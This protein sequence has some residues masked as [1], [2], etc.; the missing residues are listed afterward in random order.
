MF[1]F[2]DPHAPP[3]HHLGGSYTPPPGSYTPPPIKPYRPP[4]PTSYP[5]TT[6]GPPLSPYKEAGYSQDNYL[7]SLHH[8][9]HEEN[10]N[11]HQHLNEVIK[12]YYNPP[13]ISP[14]LPTLYYDD[15]GQIK[16]MPKPKLP[17]LV[18]HN[19]HGHD[20]H[21]PPKS[22][23]GL[24][25]YDPRNHKHHYKHAGTNVMH[26]GSD[27]APPP[28]HNPH[29]NGY[30]VSTLAP[31][32]PPFIKNIFHG[33]THKPA[34]GHGS[35]TPY[36]LWNKSTTPKPSYYGSTTPYSKVKYST[37]KPTT[38]KS[39]VINKST[40]APKIH[41]NPYAYSPT[42]SPST[43]LSS[44][45]V[46]SAYG[47][48]T[49]HG[50]KEHFTAL[51]T[52][53]EYSTKH[54]H[55]DAKSYSIFNFYTT[56][57][58]VY[59]PE[60][61][62]HKHI[63]PY[64]PPPLI[65]E[66][67]GSPPP[68]KDHYHEPH[69]EV[70]H[71]PYH[72]PKLD[73][74]HIVTPESHHID[75]YHHKP[76]LTTSIKPPTPYH[77]TTIKPYHSP[78]ITLSHSTTHLPHHKHST[79]LAPHYEQHHTP[80]LPIHPYDLPHHKHSTTLAPHYEKHH[81]PDLPIHPYESPHPPELPGVSHNPYHD[82]M[83]HPPPDPHH[84][85]THDLVHHKPGH[86]EHHEPVHHKPV[87]HEPPYHPKPTPIP[88]H[89]GPPSHH[90][91]HHPPPAHHKEPHHHP[92]PDFPHGPH[93]PP[94]SHPHPP[95][96]HNK[97]PYHHKKPPVH[98]YNDYNLPHVD[99]LHPYHKPAH[100]HPYHPSHPPHDY[101][102]P[103]GKPPAYG[104]HYHPK[105]YSV[106]D[107]S[108]SHL[109]QKDQSYLP[110][111]FHSIY[112]GPGVPPKYP[113]VPL[114]EPPSYPP[115][116]YLLGLNR[117]EEKIE[118]IK[119]DDV[120]ALKDALK[121]A[122]IGPG[123]KKKVYLVKEKNGETHVQISLPVQELFE[124]SEE[125]DDRSSEALDLSSLGRSGLETT[126]K[127]T[128]TKRTTTTEPTTT[129]S[130]TTRDANLVQLL[131]PQ[132]TTESNGRPEKLMKFEMNDFWLQMQK[133]FKP[134]QIL[135]KD[136]N[137]GTKLKNILISKQKDEDYDEDY[138]ED[139]ED[140]AYEYGDY[141]EDY[142]EEDKS[143]LKMSL[144]QVPANQ[145]DL[146]ELLNQV[147]SDQQNNQLPIQSQDPINVIVVGNAN[148]F[149][150]RQQPKQNNNVMFPDNPRRPG[151]VQGLTPPIP[152]SGFR[153]PDNTQGLRAPIPGSGFR[154]PDN[155]QGL[156]APIPG[157]GFRQ[158]DNTGGL[159]APIPG[160]GFRQPDNTQGFRPPIPGSGFRQPDN[161]QGLR[162]P[163][164][165]S[166]FRQPDN[167]QGFSAPIPGSGF[168]QP[169]N[170]NG[171]VV[172]NQQFFQNQ[173][174]Q[175]NANPTSRIDSAE[176]EELIETSGP[177]DTRP[178]E[179]NL[180]IVTPQPQTIRTSTEP[181]T[182]TESEAKKVLES[183]K[184]T[185]DGLVNSVDGLN[186]TVAV[187]M[188][189]K[190]KEI[191]K[192]EPSEQ[193]RAMQIEIA[194]LTKMVHDLRLH[195]QQKQNQGFMSLIT[196]T[197]NMLKRQ[198]ENEQKE[199]ARPTFVTPSTIQVTTTRFTTISTTTTTRTTTTTTASTTSYNWFTS[200]PT[201]RPFP[202]QAV[203]SVTVQGSESQSNNIDT[204][205]LSNINQVNETFIH[206]ILHSYS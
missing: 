122:G 44:I 47:T 155:T 151:K 117:T 110:V 160:S 163:L 54:P 188:E 79:T 22:V 150:Q 84:D 154:Q 184:S 183:L 78:A 199:K 46:P 72:P 173:L 14:D 51:P 28:V 59:V 13:P 138:E 17:G 170:N 93:G 92:L 40:Y 192:E 124:D 69:P 9:Y 165:G 203:Q 137:K 99:H 38:V 18:A 157:S 204:G 75:P 142:E 200:E 109:P 180:L 146:R 136:G 45:H 62:D 159:R 111:G 35:T 133:L 30:K 116:P 43:T 103:K 91:E 50:K 172:P 82:I 195:N 55:K 86:H 162:S 126:T 140:N 61:H 152:G 71:K 196:Q 205:L 121:K 125:F 76:H 120:D 168:R 2:T 176:N 53:I 104:Y 179:S 143:K 12:E 52:N 102:P 100:D 23:K 189:E 63:E 32:V 25:T 144:K 3:K 49:P 94:G 33:S 148:T 58:P 194:S 147:N 106:P 112:N 191:M 113:P 175:L 77:S 31:H 134:G 8:D 19:P 37:P 187:S 98:H 156:R 114:G 131:G 186:H 96:Y 158:P 108:V 128:T 197:Q 66:I 29:I 118:K 97:D 81:P 34:H 10:L 56:P 88:Q 202:L 11:D 5:S 166:G 95:D 119:I 167:T 4:P 41:N 6:Y 80:D 153:Q 73:A 90:G 27:F 85:Y 20:P 39:I 83:T 123:S 15:L 149:R 21:A 16:H 115:R 201:Q 129:T 60:K 42:A 181:T 190:S 185:L 182:T 164:P 141:E 36:P 26:F 130:T 64:H 67:H 87:H 68:P 24:K 7:P 105:H 101:H 132:T 70:H 57:E 127:T 174:N 48:P 177:S 135:I 145:L 107:S 1:Y 178:S 206:T 198:E 139:Y 161:T 169:D 171:L 74:V 193:V 89:Y 65:K